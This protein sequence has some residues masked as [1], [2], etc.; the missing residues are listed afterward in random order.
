M[1]TTRYASFLPLLLIALLLSGALGCSHT[2]QR[3]MTVTAYCNCSSCCSWTRGSWKFLKINFWNRYYNG[4]PNKGQPYTG[5]TASGTKPRQYNP[6][7]FSLNTLVRPWMIPPRLLVPSLI[8]S[9]PGSV[10]ADTDYYPFGTI[11]D[12]PGYGRGIVEDRG[13][14]IKGPK[15]LDIYYRSHSRALRWGRQTI[16]ITIHKP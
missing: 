15:R 14:A 5:R 1:S 16:P 10:A 12:I 2:K 13:S 11:L 3:T 9:H 6:G 8:F 4:G 7:L